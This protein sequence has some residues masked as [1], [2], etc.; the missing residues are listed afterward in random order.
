[1]TTLDG[2]LK[3]LALHAAHVAAQVADMA[4]SGR[5]LKRLGGELAL[6]G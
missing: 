1:V 6:R 5:A 3:I 4:G 2:P